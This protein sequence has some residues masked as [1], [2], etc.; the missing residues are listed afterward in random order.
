MVPTRTVDEKRAEHIVQSSYKVNNLV[1]K[2]TILRLHGHAESRTGVTLAAVAEGEVAAE[3]APAVVTRRAGHAAS[4]DEVLG[5][6]GRTNLAR[7]R[8]AGG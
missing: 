8:C 6:C 5:R 7:L 3:G 4:P 2:S 1:I